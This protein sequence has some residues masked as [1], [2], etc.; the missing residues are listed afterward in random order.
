M[1]SKERV[2]CALRK[3]KPDRVPIYNSFTP[4]IVEGLCRHFHCLPDELDEVIG[5]D[6]KRISFSPPR[7]FHATILTDGSFT[8]EWGIVY[9]RVG[10][11]DEMIAHP[12]SDLKKINHYQFPDPW[13]PGRFDQAKKILQNNHHQLATMGFLGSTNFEPAWYLVGLEKFLIEFYEENPVIDYILDQ[14]LHFYQAISQQLISLGIDIIMCGDDVG[15]QQGMMI[16]PQVWRKRLKPRLEQLFKTFRQSNP[17]IIIIY[18]S[19]GNIEPII[20]DLIELGLDVLN[21]IQPKCM[22]PADIKRKYGDHLAFFG[23]IDEQETLPFLNEEEV[24][25]EVKLRIETVGY[26]GGLLLG[27]THNIQP[28]TP[29]KN[30]T[31]MYDEVQSNPILF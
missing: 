23:T 22:N 13:A 9:K 26:N 25:R 20:P 1:T 2:L 31:A 27:A 4:Q 29:I 7:S 12:L 24:R 28:D 15:T 14:T 16:S 21:P 5:N 8:D 30:I 3:I 17:E 19:D 10:Y 18:H 11:Y 6:V